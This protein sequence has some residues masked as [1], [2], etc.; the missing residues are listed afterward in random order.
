M[1][2]GIDAMAERSSDVTQDRLIAQHVQAHGW[3]CLHVSA[4]NDD[5]DPFSCSIGFW[6]TFQ[7]PEVLV[8]GLPEE[9]A[10]AILGACHLRLKDG[11]SIVP[12]VADDDILAG[13]YPVMF[14]AL[15]EDQFPEYLGTAMRFYDDKPF[16][17]L[18]MFLPDREHRYAWDAGYAG[19]SAREALAIV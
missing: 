18:V 2:P 10:H 9:Q 13:G 19:P 12:D 3:H 6:A 5:E 8:F 1:L 11:G 7:A 4:E 14:K 16:P 17:A 15:C